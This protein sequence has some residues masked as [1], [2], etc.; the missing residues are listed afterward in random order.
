MLTIRRALAVSLFALG[1]AGLV[2]PLAA[3]EQGVTVEA[4]IARDVVDREPVDGGTVFPVDVERLFCWMRVQGAEPGTVIEHVW[5]FA[6]YEW[7]VP[8]E[9]GGTHWRT[10]SNKT[11]LPEWTGEWTVEIR[12]G[13]GNVLETVA[14][15]VQ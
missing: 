7:V 3:Q 10:F 14:F 15:T 9:I 11:I 8:L 4:V 13:T 12:D 5:K 2:A 6:G 1:V